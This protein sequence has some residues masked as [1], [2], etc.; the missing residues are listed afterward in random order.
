MRVLKLILYFSFFITLNT[1]CFSQT[2]FVKVNC[3]NLK[4]T[5][6]N[7]IYKLPTAVDSIHVAH[8]SI[9]IDTLN[10]STKSIKAHTKLTVV[11]KLNTVA[12]ISISLLQLVVDSIIENQQQL[13]YSYNDTTL[14]ITPT[15]VLNQNDSITLSVYYHGKP[16]QDITGWGGFYFKDG[17]A[18]NMGIGFGANPHTIGKMWFPCLDEFTDRATYEFHITTASTQKAFCNGALTSETKN[19]NGT[20]IW[21]WYLDKTI[22]TY[23]ACVAAAPY[24]TI[25][26]TIAGIPVELAVMADDSLNAIASF[27]HLPKVLKGFIN[28]YGDYPFNKVGFSMVPFDAGAMEHASQITIGINEIDGTLNN[29]TIWAHELSHAWWGDKVTCETAGDMWLNE[30]WASFNE[31]L[32][33]QIVYGDDAYKNWVRDNHQSV[34]QMAHITDGSYLSFADVPHAVTYGTTVYSKGADAVYTLR[35]YLGDSLFFAACK[36]HLNKRAYNNSNSIQLRDDFTSATGIDMTRFFDDWI[37]T[38]GFPHFSIDSVIPVGSNQYAVYIRQRSKGSNRIYKMPVEINFTD[39]KKTKTVTVV[40]D[41]LTQ[42]YLLS[43][44]FKPTWI[45]IDRDEK[46]S[47][48]ISDCEKQITT[49]GN[50]D[51]P[52]TNVKL[53]VTNFGSGNTIVRIE[54]NWVKPDNWIKANPGIRLSNY[55]Y[56]KLD[57]I[58]DANFKSK[59]LFYINGSTKSATGYIDNSLITGKEDS[60]VILWRTG[61]GYDW[62]IVTDANFDFGNNH[63]DKVCS[64]TV[65]E[66]KK[67]EYT[68]GYYDCTAAGVSFPT[69]DEINLQIKQ[70]VTNQLCRFSFDL[71]NINQALLQ[72]LDNKGNLAASYNIFSNQSFIDWDAS[73][74]KA[75]TYVATFCIDGKVSVSKNFI[76]KK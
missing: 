30:G 36:Y 49:T 11:A 10:F 46:I 13:A 19:K 75:G 14:S 32:M 73:S 68:L 4:S 72:V 23:L 66:I 28:A 40:S 24:Y 15:K 44:P 76:L 57:G 2:S 18:F 7:S 17:Y 1:K 37:F 39:G 59:A 55:H 67:G 34:L 6:V 45:S 50:V 61:A 3:N 29:E 47:D 54:H 31:A 33:L 62:H 69:E 22:P 56:W 27:Q 5:S 38:A 51:M 43:I 58:W 41:S 35:N 20:V 74:T 12:T 21:N 52:N 64:V 65:D 9:C 70:N 25:K 71:K 48:A 63:N 16:K 26:N 60:L 42:S 53:D 8:Y